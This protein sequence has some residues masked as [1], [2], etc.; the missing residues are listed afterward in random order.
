[1]TVGLSDRL[2]MVSPYGA[3]LPPESPSPH[4]SSATFFGLRINTSPSLP[5]GLYMTTADAGANLVEFCPVEPFATLSIVRGYRDPGACRDGAAPL[6]KP[7][8]AKSGDVVEVSSRGISVNGALLPNTAPL[9]RDTK[10]RHLRSLAVRAVCRRSRNRMGRLLLSSAQLRQSLLWPAVDCGD[11]PS[12]EGIPNPMN[13]RSRDRLSFCLAIGIGSGCINWASPGHHRGGRDAACV[14][15]T[16]NA[17]GGVRK[18]GWL[19][20]S[21]HLADGPRLESLLRAIRDFSYPCC[22]VGPRRNP[23]LGAMDHCLDIQSLPLLVAS[24]TRA[25]RYNR[26]SARN[27]RSCFSGH[28]VGLPFSR[29]GLGRSRRGRAPARDCS[30][31]ARFGFT[32]TLRCFMSR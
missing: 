26:P 1:M 17:Q 12:V 4:S 10:G 24:A 5:M 9:T 7:I 23:A 22:D 25:L 18:H 11:S 30:L 15:N 32:P 27:Y 20:F 28:G 19:L 29:N 21:R 31:D 2:R 8:V 14:P 3:W 16:R 13:V 6:L